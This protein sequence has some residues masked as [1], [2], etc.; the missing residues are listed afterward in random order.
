MIGDFDATIKEA[1]KQRLIKTKPK[2]RDSL[3][4]YLI[5]SDSSAN[6]NLTRDELDLML[7]KMSNQIPL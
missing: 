7:N 4:S 1:S 2:Y 5:R 6:P 3:E